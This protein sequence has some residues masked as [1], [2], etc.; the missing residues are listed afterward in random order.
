MKNSIF[1]SIG[2]KIIFFYI[3][4]TM[5]NVSFV[6]SI[7]FE[8]QVD[9]ITK[10]SKLE[11]EQQISNLIGSL[12]KFSSEIKKGTLF[13]YDTDP[14]S[15]DQFVNLIRPHASS[16][17]IVTEDNRT[18]YKSDSSLEPPPTIAEDIL[19]S[20]TTEN[21]SGKD[22]YLR[23]DDRKRIMYCYI[24]LHEFRLG[25]SVLLVQKDISGVDASLRTLYY[26]A[27]YVIFVVL[28]F[29]AVFALILFRYLITPIKLLRQ[30]AHKLAEGDLGARISLTD[31]D[32]E[33]GSLAASFNKMA[34]SIAAN[35]GA[36]TG[37]VKWAIETKNRTDI[38]TVKDELTGLFSR[39]YMIERINEEIKKTL[40]NKSSMALILIEID[41]FTDIIK[42]YGNNSG[43]ILVLEVSKIIMRNF[44]D[45]DVVSRFSGESIAVLTIGRPVEQ[46]NDLAEKIRHEIEHG[47]IITPDGT[48]SVTASIGVSFR[49]SGSGEG[50]EDGNDLIFSAGTALAQ[51]RYK[52]K[53]RVEIIP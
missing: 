9:L 45:T 49:S 8:N 12:K 3:L 36:L 37:K 22:Y 51:A 24:P 44:S 48:F 21:F 29:H 18:R 4:L 30:G 11:S 42:I 41:T 47:T 50:H 52:G 5:I 40:D 53:N 38:L 39:I 1:Q 26:Q 27:L 28:F 35:M 25:K 33:F 14:G 32:D 23:I 31:Q 15:L 20:I 2:F 34:D 19:R 46:I 6:I 16:F 13:A 17:Y 7:I 10:N 43:D